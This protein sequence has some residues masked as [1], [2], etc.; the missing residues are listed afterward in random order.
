[1]VYHRILRCLNQF[2]CSFSFQF[3]PSWK[4]QNSNRS[5]LPTVVYK[6]IHLFCFMKIVRKRK[7]VYVFA[8]YP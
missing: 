3:R 5:L 2:L 8:K 1:M 4:G 6:G 7:F